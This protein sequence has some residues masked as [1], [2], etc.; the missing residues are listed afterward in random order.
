M[1]GNGG[2]TIDVKEQTKK[3]HTITEITR[4]IKSTV[5]NKFTG[6]WLAGEVSNVRKPGSGHIYLTLKDNN[7][8]LQAVIFRSVANRIRFDLKDG[9][10]VI[11]YGSVTVYEPRGQ[12]Q[13]IIESVEPK[14]IGALQLAF[15]QLK[16]K[17]HK[18]GLFDQDKKKPI[19]FLPQKIAIVTSPTG[20]AIQDMLSI[21]NRRCPCV[22]IILYP[23]KVQGEGAAEEIA[24][25]ISYIN[26]LSDIDV[27]IIGRGGGSIEDLWA[28]NEE[29]VARSIFKSK[30]PIISAVGHEIDVTI[31]DFVADKRALTPSEA[32]EMVVPRLDMLVDSVNLLKTRLNRSLHN[33]L[34]VAKNRLQIAANSYALRKPLDR[35]HNLQQKL[36]DIMQR[37]GSSLKYTLEIKKSKLSNFAGKLESLSP[38]GIL[39]RGYSLTTKEGEI[40]PIKFVHDLQNGDKIETRLSGGNVISVVENIK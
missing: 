37:F 12:Y 39:K 30:I 38:L 11:V 2:F 4:L 3:F 28:F 25:A 23:V 35:V 20:A 32:G 17:L 8:Q 31:S 29:V 21:I 18:L 6:V 36:D 16:S 24:Q 5:E 22:K 15:E 40:K 10:E 7:A 34:L 33:K 14:G 27:M 19:P 13:I 26:D 9:T 1:N